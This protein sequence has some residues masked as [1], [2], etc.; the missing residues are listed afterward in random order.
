MTFVVSPIAVNADDLLQNLR[1]VADRYAATGADEN[2]FEAFVGDLSDLGEVTVE[3]WRT[4]GTAQRT[5]LRKF[6]LSAV[7]R[8]GL[9]EEDKRRALDGLAVE[10]NERLRELLSANLRQVPDTSG[11]PL[12]VGQMIYLRTAV[13]AFNRLRQDNQQEAQALSIV[14]GQLEKGALFAVLPM[15]IYSDAEKINIAMSLGVRGFDTEIESK[16]RME[17]DSIGNPKSARLDTFAR[18][19]KSL[20]RLPAIKPY[21]MSDVALHYK[22]EDVLEYLNEHSHNELAQAVLEY[23]TYMGLE[24]TH[25]P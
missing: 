4:I 8:K 18:V 24:Q 5:V 1:L 19:K 2:S 15:N 21:R 22:A 10:I 13:N 20:T 14:M 6:E 17:Y 11:I 25:E 7:L 3:I 12:D 16:L 23:R 9:S